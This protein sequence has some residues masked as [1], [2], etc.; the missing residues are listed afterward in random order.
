MNAA[1]RA[2][3]L[4]F[5]LRFFFL[6]IPLPVRALPTATLGFGVCG[7]LPRAAASC[8]CWG[9][10]IHRDTS[11]ACREPALLAGAFGCARSQRV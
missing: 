10:K 9:S 8:I 5:S 11:T 7:L 4:C 3:P 1:E 2:V 6:Q